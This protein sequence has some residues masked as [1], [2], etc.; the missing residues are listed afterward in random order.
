MKRKDLKKFVKTL[1][2]S[3]QLVDNSNPVTEELK[4]ETG[5]KVAEIDHQIGR[6]KQSELIKKLED[7]EGTSLFLLHCPNCDSIHFRHAGYVEVVVP[8]TEKENEVKTIT[9]S[10]PVK[11]CVEC[12]HSFFQNDGRLY[13]VTNKIDLNAWETT[14]K[15]MHKVTGPGGQC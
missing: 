1:I 14:E 7:N 5:V 8:Y 2:K 13:D 15:M 6:F 11:M 3:K 10:Q 12:K 9:A 4:T